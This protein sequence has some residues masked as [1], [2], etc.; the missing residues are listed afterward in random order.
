LFSVVTISVSNFTTDSWSVGKQSLNP[1]TNEFACGQADE[2]SV[3]NV[4][5]TSK[6]TT[7]N[8]GSNRT[9]LTELRANHE[10]AVFRAPEG[11][12]DISLAIRHPLTDYLLIF[13]ATENAANDVIYVRSSGKPVLSIPDTFGRPRFV[14]VL[15]ELEKSNDSSIIYLETVGA[16]DGLKITQ[17]LG[18]ESIHLSEILSREGFTAQIDPFIS[19]AFPCV[20]STSFRDGVVEVPNLVMDFFPLASTSPLWISKDIVDFLPITVRSD[21]H[22]FEMNLVIP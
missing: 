18:V 19:M 16:L 21:Q 17:P 14:P 6:V 9:S 13:V 20:A 5:D 2:L 1:L 22:A 15:I 4:W 11:K 8:S 10:L 3:P 7:L 12:G